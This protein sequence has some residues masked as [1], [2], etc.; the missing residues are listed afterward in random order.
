MRSIWM[1]VS[2]ALA[3][4]GAA[5]LASA[6]GFDCAK[7]KST[8]ERKICAVPELSGLDNEMTQ[9]F[10]QARAKAGP[11]LDA[12]LRDQRN[13]LGERDDAVINGDATSIYLERI[14]FLQRV[15]DAPPT[16][17]PLLAAIVK[18]LARQPP[19]MLLGCCAGMEQVMGGDGS[20]FTPATEQ[21]FDPAQPLPFDTGPLIKAYKDAWGDVI[22]LLRLDA[23][24]LV[25]LYASEG[26]ENCESWALFSWHGKAIQSIHN[27]ILFSDDN[28]VGDSGDFNWLVEYQGHAYALQSH[29]SGVVAGEIEVQQWNGDGWGALEG[30]HVRYDYRTVPKYARCAVADCTELTA[31][32]SK[33]LA[34]YVQS[35]DI[36]AL[37]GYVP[38]DVRARFETEQELAEKDGSVD[39]MP[40]GGD[41]SGWSAFDSDSK[42]FPIR[43]QGEWLLARI[44]NASLFGKY[45]S[46]SNDDFLLG[47]WRWDGHVFVPMLG[48]AAPT[49]RTGFL[50]AIYGPLV[51][52]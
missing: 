14:Q 15:F 18:H 21:S 33:V 3:L 9:A 30:V 28:C 46:D 45:S 36:D 41:Y 32:A 29:D 7:A 16:D 37:V 39:V 5:P 40:W 24:H 44:G 4:L 34:R 47:F 26:R 38:V 48:M 35:H 51:S 27:P 6:A 50:L 42:F 11:Q 13:W 19:A 52:D 20:V 23:V 12:L 43:W 31:L 22:T 10:A 49:Q 17:A 1:K 8:V 25:G 2:L